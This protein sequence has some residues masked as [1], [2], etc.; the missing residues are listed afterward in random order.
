MRLIVSAAARA[1]QRPHTASG[2]SATSP[3]MKPA[4]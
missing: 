2:S 3:A 4:A 1:P